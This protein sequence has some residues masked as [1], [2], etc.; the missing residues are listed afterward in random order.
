MTS[1]TRHAL[2]RKVGGWITYQRG[3]SA[4]DEAGPTMADS[5]AP[6]PTLSPTP[7]WASLAGSRPMASTRSRSSRSSMDSG[8]TEPGLE[9][10]EKEPS[11]TTGDAAT[12]IGSSP[13]PP[14]VPRRLAKRF[15][16][17]NQLSPME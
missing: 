7:P 8:S 9:A 12:S 6:S 3:S 15:F 1:L 16:Q 2:G 11:T 5:E 4:A 10:P 14:S 17:L 13:R